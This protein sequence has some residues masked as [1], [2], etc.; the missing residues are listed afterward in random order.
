MLRDLP[1]DAAGEVM[2]HGDLIPGNVL[3]ADG[4]LAGVIDV[5]GLGPADPALDLVGA[6]HLL[7]A[8]PRQV[9][10]DDLECDELEWARGKAWAFQQAI[11]AVWYYVESNPAMSS[12]G[13]HTLKRIMAETSVA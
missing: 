11:G 12:M 9:L 4:S 2:T 7:D 5:G 13:R 10:R 1:R 3:V 6:W 8:G